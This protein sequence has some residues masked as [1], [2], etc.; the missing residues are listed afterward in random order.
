MLRAIFLTFFFAFYMFCFLMAFA[1]SL[2]ATD[3]SNINRVG[4]L[5]LKYTLGAT[6]GFA[7]FWYIS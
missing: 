1:S 2:D 7:I 6:V 3:S 5:A 4:N